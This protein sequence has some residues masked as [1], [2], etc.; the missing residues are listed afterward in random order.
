MPAEKITL[1]VFPRP[2]TATHPLNLRLERGRVVVAEVAACRE[3]GTAQ[4][5]VPA[6][7]SQTPSHTAPTRT[8][9]QEAHE[10]QD[11]QAVREAAGVAGGGQGAG[12]ARGA[13]AIAAI[14]AEQ[15]PLL[16]RHRARLT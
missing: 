10:G 6:P 16:L 8:E 9:S 14:G 13:A 11:E 4:G 15:R 1:P 2:P 5:P 12:R 7:A 3:K